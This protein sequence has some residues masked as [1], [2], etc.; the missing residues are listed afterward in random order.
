MTWIIYYTTL[1]VSSCVSKDS[2]AKRP[3]FACRDMTV[4]DDRVYM[5]VLKF[6]R[7]GKDIVFGVIQ[8]P[9]HQ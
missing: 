5:I 1:S 8:S 2:G 4:K 9:G 7:R 3:M 6:S